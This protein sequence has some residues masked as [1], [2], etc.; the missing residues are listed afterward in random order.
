LLRELVLLGQAALVSKHSHGPSHGNILHL[1]ETQHCQPQL[2]EPRRSHQCATHQVRSVIARSP[3]VHRGRSPAVRHTIAQQ[4][5]AN[6]GMCASTSG[7]GGRR[8]STPGRRL[9]RRKFSPDDVPLGGRGSES[10]CG[11]DEQRL[12]RVAV[13]RGMEDFR[14]QAVNV[15][16]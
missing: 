8:A 2:S 9:R 11:A 5:S 7:K 16:D 12:E 10:G 3:S 13:Y 6:S 1:Q 4:P 14:S 15:E